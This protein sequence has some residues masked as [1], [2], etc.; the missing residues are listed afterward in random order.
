MDAHV[1]A[2]AVFDDGSGPA[3]FV[4]G[5][6]DHAGGV[7]CSS[8]ARWKNGVW[9]DVGGGLDGAL[10]DTRAHALCVHDDGSG[11]ALYVGGN[12]TGAG[13]IAA[14]KIARWNGSSW[15]AVGGGIQGEQ[16]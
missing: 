13:G 16:G 3:L 12:F 9:S 11:A 8:I 1:H 10:F 15:S 7:A 5:E 14:S 2:L 6:F 4:A